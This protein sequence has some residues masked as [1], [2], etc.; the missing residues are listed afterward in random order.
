MY[1]FRVLACFFL[2]ALAGLAQTPTATVSGV[3]R[4]GQG[5]VVAGAKVTGIN[6]ATGVRTNTETNESGIYSLRQLAIGEHDIEVEQPGFRRSVQQG[7]RLT[8]GQSLELNLTLEVGAVTESIT[9]AANASV[10]ETRSS[11]VSQLVETRSVEDLPLG[12]RRSMNL[13]RI[14]GAAVMV[15]YDSGQKP[16][17]SLAGGRTQSQMFWIDGGTAQNMRLGAGQVDMDPPVETLQE[18][19]VLSSAYAAEF[20]GSNGGAIIATTKSG[21]N[22]LHGSLF[23]YFRNE[24]LDAPG[25]FAPIQDGKKTRAPLRYNV[26]GGTVGGPIR[27]DKTFFFFGY[28]GSRRR[29]GQT[30]TLTVPTALQK[31]GDFSQTLNAQGNVIPVYDPATTVNQGGRFVRQP[32]AG[33][34][35]P[36]DRLDPVALNVVKF[37]PLPNKPPDNV[38]G[39][40][41]FR[42]NYV[43]TLTRDNFNVKVDHNIGASH[44]LTGRYLYNSDDV[45]NT[46]VFPEPAADTLNE[47]KRH[48]QYWYGAWNY[49][50][51][52]TV[53]ND[54]RFTYSNR[55]N[56]ARSPSVGGN[57]VSQIG[58]QGV[59]DFAFPQMN[60]SGVTGLG[61]GAQERAQFPIEQYQIVNNLSWIRG[62][63]AFKFG[64]E[65]R[66][67]MN[68]ETNKPTASGSF[69][70]SPL[71]TGLPGTAASGLGMASLLTGF[72]QGFNTRETEVLDRYSHYI[73]WFAQDDWT[74][75]RDLTLNL[76]VRW[77]TDTPI[78]DRNQRMN[79]FDPHQINP[80]SGTPGVV[81]FA[82]VDG[83]RTTPY[84]TDM[85]NFGPR[86]GF[87]WKAL[88]SNTT[89]VRGGFGVF[90]AHPFD[91]GAPNSASLGYEISASR[92]SPDNGVTPAFY[93]REGV[94]GISL[95]KPPLD[96]NF[97][98]VRVGQAAT[99][100]VL[101]YEQDRR[102][103]YSMQFNLGVQRELP[104]R[105]IVE[106]QYIGNLSR[107]LASP[108]LP[109][110]QIL[111]ERMGPGTAQR[112]RPFP[113]FNNVAL[114]LPTLGV[115]SY[116]AGLLRVERRFSGGFSLLGTYTWANNQ[117]NTSEGPGGS[118]GDDGGYSNLYNRRA[119]W[120][121]SGNDI[122]H[123]ATLT[124]V[125]EVPVGKGRRYL[126]RH[127][128]GHVLGGWSF[129]GLLALQTGEPGTVTTQVNTTNAFSAGGLRADVLRNP[130]LPDDQR[131][132]DRWFDT[133]AFVQPAPYTFGNSGINL[134]RSP[135]FAQLDLS[136]LRNFTLTE[137]KRIQLRGELFNITN[138]TNF[139]NPGRTLGGPGFGIIAGAAA[140]R[141]IQLGL[142]F[143][144]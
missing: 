82:G 59:K 46:S 105:F 50:L 10:L 78:T 109:L 38:A 14:T 60:A 75:S 30:R 133:D 123:R 99:T 126:A 79:M 7:V 81:K 61:S 31:A 42:S 41:N 93:L 107:K 104:G 122:R 45:G 85:N 119:D 29:D 4:D 115:A 49:T 129:G 144:F 67:S 62:R 15:G 83:Y 3:V 70:F 24:K 97:G 47:T 65:F 48:Q 74:I 55:I 121:P 51:S 94:Q 17:F 112:D 102:T 5:A 58:I 124:G 113:Q 6:L 19:K 135:G 110:N 92:T 32:F 140:P 103:G 71:G 77:E 16:N 139:G 53:L 142:R 96:D 25:F 73:A 128:L 87:A 21:T 1:S 8:T 111:P 88:G 84:D 134:V 43:S 69:T 2:A 130:N 98:A 100:N 80:V 68:Y 137:S 13:I 108:N 132:L 101:F 72:V 125:L 12:D 9:V 106:T 136:I 35:I 90:F 44:R 116:H 127:A 117:N 131:R 26:F 54:F 52:P 89:V 66:P 118:L 22:Q 95:T 138:N 27:P 57:W 141:Q 91:A 40:N 64:G 18:V 56:H 11:D 114:Q 20:G 63:H 143:V 28:E 86:F 39:A 33:N 36:T 76:G 34:R 120:G 37:Y 23:E